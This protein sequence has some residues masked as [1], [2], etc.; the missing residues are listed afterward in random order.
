MYPGLL[1]NDP[2]M[3]IQYALEV[4]KSRSILDQIK[5]WNC[6]VMNHDG[7]LHEELLKML[8]YRP[9]VYGDDKMM[10]VAKY[11]KEWNDDSERGKELY[12]F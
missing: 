9:Y 2:N 7:M 11:M 8:K 1:Q 6:G 12:L 4:Q 5:H 3:A 10:E